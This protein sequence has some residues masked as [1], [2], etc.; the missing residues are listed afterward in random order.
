MAQYYQVLSQNDKNCIEEL[1]QYYPNIVEN[2]TVQYVI[3]PEEQQHLQGQQIIVTSGD[4]LMVV[5]SESQAVVIEQPQIYQS[6]T[7]QQYVD[8]DGKVKYQPSGNQQAY[9]TDKGNSLPEPVADQSIPRQ[10]VHQRYYM[11]GVQENSRV[12]DSSVDQKIQQPVI[13]NHQIQAAQIANQ[14]V[15]VSMPKNVHMVQQQGSVD[16]ARQVPGQS[17]V[18]QQL[19]VI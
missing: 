16:Q 5:D 19:Q 3:S 14:L 6:A 10:N 2:Q 18:R 12:I 17:P 9:Y 11:K 7:Q 13:L 1:R 4:Q 8:Q 15:T